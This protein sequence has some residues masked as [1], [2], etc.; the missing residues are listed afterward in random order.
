MCSMSGKFA[1]SIFFGFQGKLPPTSF[2]SDPDPRD[3][4]Y[5]KKT[6]T[7]TTSN[8]YSEGRFFNLFMIVITAVCDSI[9]GWNFETGNCCCKVVNGMSQF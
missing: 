9:K 4:S 7:K 8:Q 5:N 1:V 6:V 3:E 2:A